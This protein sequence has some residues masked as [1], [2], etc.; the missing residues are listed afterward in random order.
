MPDGPTHEDD[1]ASRLDADERVRL[2]VEASGLGTWSW[3]AQTGEVVWDG[4]LERIYGLERGTF[5]RTYEAYLELLHPADREA[6]AA[7]SAA[8]MKAGGDHKVEHRVIWPDG[9]IHWIEGW[10]RAV[11]SPDGTPRGLVGVSADVTERKLHEERLRQLQAVTA[12]LAEARTA[13]EV[14]RIAL[15]EVVVA[16]EAVGSTLLLLEGDGVHINV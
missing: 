15:H 16:T 1:A 12:A 6:V 9:S 4:A 3:N 5:P 7:T 2:A 10:G 14:G 11:K 8:S 13:D